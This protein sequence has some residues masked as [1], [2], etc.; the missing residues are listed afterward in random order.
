MQVLV[1][2]T[3]SLTE[4]FFMWTSCECSYCILFHLFEAGPS[5]HQ[6]SAPPRN[7]IPSLF[8]CFYE[9]SVPK[10]SSV[11]SSWLPSTILIFI[12]YWCSVTSVKAFKPRQWHH[13]S[14][15]WGTRCHHIPQ[16][17]R[18][19]CMSRRSVLS[20]NCLWL[21]AL[22]VPTITQITIRTKGQVCIATLVRGSMC[23]SW[24]VFVH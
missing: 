19:Y 1:K 18:G 14:S 17:E 10:L 3:L 7:S 5:T 22:T 24:L 11:Y 13:S 15:C 2:S 16:E 12:F 23:S 20:R 9:D 6:A 21:G 8:P 4:D